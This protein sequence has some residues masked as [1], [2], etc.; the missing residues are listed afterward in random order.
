MI[1]TTKT[2]TTVHLDNNLREEMLQ[3]MADGLR[4]IPETLF[5]DLASGPYSPLKSR[6]NCIAGCSVSWDDEMGRFIH[7]EGCPLVRAIG[8]AHC[9]PEVLKN[10]ALVEE[11]LSSAAQER[12]ASMEQEG[13]VHKFDTAA[14]VCPHCEKAG[15]RNPLTHKDQKL[16]CAV[17]GNVFWAKDPSGAKSRNEA[18]Q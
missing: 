6:P 18:P 1:E 4:A 7:A 10:L 9:C 8:V 2:T 12:E 5:F 3:A 14:P 15:K 13:T 11:C 16:E 17:C